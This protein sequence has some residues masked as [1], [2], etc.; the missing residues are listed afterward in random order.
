[1]AMTEFERKLISELKG[2]G[3]E[4]RKIRKELRISTALPGIEVEEEELEELEG[5]TNGTGG[6]FT[7]TKEDPKDS[8]GLNPMLG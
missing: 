6:S 7:G 1:M 8:A 5:L 2:I 3:S 4:L